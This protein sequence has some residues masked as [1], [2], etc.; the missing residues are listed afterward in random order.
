[1]FCA[2]GFG[3]LV[4]SAR[5]GT[6]RLE[7][8]IAVPVELLD[9]VCALGSADRV[10]ARLRAYHDA[11]ADCVA[12]VPSTA[13]DPAGCAT[14]NAVALQYNPNEEMDRDAR[15]HPMPSGR[16]SDGLLN[17]SD[18]EVAE[19]LVGS[20]ADGEFLVRVE[21]VSVDLAMRTWMNAGRSYVPAVVLGEGDACWRHRASR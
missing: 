13:E 6:R 18:W 19:R 16:P 3:D 21:Y 17:I 11:G 15:Q 9:H 2:L 14:L 5:A 7:L 10:A 12:V 20:P 8:V 1:M 4:E